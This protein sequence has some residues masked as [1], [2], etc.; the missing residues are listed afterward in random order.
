L[1]NPE[2]KT[3]NDFKTSYLYQDILQINQLSRLIANFIYLDKEEETGEEKPIFPRYHQLDCVNKLLKDAV[4]GDNFLI[5]HSAGS[6]KTKTIAW[7][8][9][10]LINKFNESDNR[11]YDMVIVVSDRKVIDK[12]LQKQVQQIEK[13]KG[14]VEKIEKGSH[15]LHEALKSGSN[16][17]VSTIQK[18]PYIL[19]EIKDLPKRNYAVIVDEAHSSQTGTMARK[20]KKVLTTNNLDEAELLDEEGLDEIDESLLKEISFPSLFH[21]TGDRRNIYS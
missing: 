4:P 11:V 20:M 3:K 8:S 7:L 12:Q 10:G 9:H 2:P 14:I 13:T 21:E 17:V 6:G 1:E 18:F 5:Q 19:D 16:I 15:Q